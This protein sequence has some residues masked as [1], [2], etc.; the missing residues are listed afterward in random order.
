MTLNMSHAA[1]RTEM[2][3]TKLEVGHSIHSWLITFLLLIRHVT[4]WPW[5]LTVTFAVFWLLRSVIF[6]TKFERNGTLCDGVIAISIHVC[7]ICAVRHLGFDRKWMFT[8]PQP[9][10]LWGPHYTMSSSNTVRKC[11][12][13][14]LVIQS[15]FTARYSG[16]NFEPPISQS[17]DS[18]L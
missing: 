12:A 15:P 14:L 13:E 18:D 17:W 7:T 16:A 6:Y 2:I 5:P 8:I 10:S 3:F 11:V 9:L 1:L 4:L